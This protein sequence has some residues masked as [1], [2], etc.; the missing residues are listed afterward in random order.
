MTSLFDVSLAE[1]TR[2]RTPARKWRKFDRDVIPMW[3]ADHDF[4]PPP[5]VRQAIVE[6]LDQGDVGY[7]DESDTVRLMAEKVRRANKID[8]SSENVYV[9]QGVLPTMWLAC[10]YACRP[11]D[12]VLATDPMYYPFFE[13]AR[14][15]QAKISYV[16]L[17]EETGY[18]FDPE[19]FNQAITA[20]TKLVFLCN[21][22][23]PTGRVMTKEELKM[24]ADL[25]VDHDLTIMSDELWEDILFDGREHISIA[26]LGTEIADRTITAFGFSKTFGVAGLQIGYA[27]STNKEIMRRI[28]SIGIRETMEPAQSALRETGSL[29]LAAAR[30]ML[31][32][33]VKYYVRELVR[34]LQEVRDIAFESLGEMRNVRSLPLEGTFLTFPDVSGYGLS[35]AEMTDFLLKEAKIGVESGAD[36]GSRGEG[37]IRINIGTSKQILTEAMS[38]MKRAL[39]SLEHQTS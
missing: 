26:S 38:R 37:H 5:E 30:A 21:P 36:F 6:A 9:T 31:S 27:V 34:Y 12:E 11:G 39:D 24:I 19:K 33:S 10:K 17:D 32:D 4:S 18:R 7:A 23:N 15:A 2:R 1:M 22:H 20:R 8:I 25:A 13:T 29:S 35:S 16:P 28:K 3:I 14:A